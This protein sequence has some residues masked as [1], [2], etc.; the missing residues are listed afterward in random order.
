MEL[1]A[2]FNF[3]PLVRS[4]HEQVKKHSYSDIK[5]WKPEKFDDLN[6][7]LLSNKD[8]GL[9]WRPFELLNPVIYAKCVELICSEENW[10]ILQT[11]FG[12]Y[13][14]GIVE[15]CS[16]PVV[17]DDPSEQKKRSNFELV[18]KG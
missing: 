17:P 1:P 6:Y 12:E 10:K 13:S 14:K 18:E 4:V 9:S 15:C 11:R 5:S 7:V 2:Y 3:E 8:G 16:L